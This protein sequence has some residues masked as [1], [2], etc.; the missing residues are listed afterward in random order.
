MQMKIQ[1]PWGISV[2]GAASVNAIP[3][4]VR[5]RIA[6]D[7]TEDTP[8][9]AF[10]AA[11]GGV[12]ALRATFRRYGI[13]DSA[14]S[15]SRLGL[16]TEWE[17]GY[18][19]AN[20]LL[21]YRC[22]ADFAV[23]LSEMDALEQLL[24]DAVQAG[25]NRVDG[26]DFDVRAKPELRARARKD[27]VR[28]AR[29]KAELYAEAAGARLGRLL[30]IEDVDSENPLASRYRSHAVDA[31]PTDADLAPGQVVVQAAVLLGFALEAQDPQEE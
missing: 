3:D 4:L 6:V 26:V 20:R 13:A 17:G 5:L 14:V 11:R 10:D 27:A 30:H 15:S 31:P 12:A 1:D 21:G 23:S 18:G 16:R 28:A 29:R 7:R 8:G 9:A 19:K 2:Y 22:Q 25:A 24:V